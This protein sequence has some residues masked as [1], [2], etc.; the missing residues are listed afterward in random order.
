MY[1]IVILKY[2]LDYKIIKVIYYKILKLKTNYLKYFFKNLHFWIYKYS[3]V[4]LFQR[5]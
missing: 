1:N 3:T 2:I 4:E 5:K